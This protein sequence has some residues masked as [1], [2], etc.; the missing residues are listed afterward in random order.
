MEPGL[1]ETSGKSLGAMLAYEFCGTALM[2][3]TYNFADGDSIT[4]SIAYLVGWMF[5][6]TVS[7]AHFNP[8]TT[9]AV[10]IY[11]KNF[12]SHIRHLLLFMFAQFAGAYAGILMVFS[13]VS[14]KDNKF[15]LQHLIRYY[16][17]CDPYSRI[18]LLFAQSTYFFF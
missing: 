2:V 9:L 14:G 6:V 12:K 11:E 8:A 16:I 7:G 4:R 15:D 18:P 1:P 10:F 5:A 13:I 3:Y 17:P